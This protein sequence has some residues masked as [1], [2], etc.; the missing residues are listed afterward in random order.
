MQDKKKMYMIAIGAC[1]LA[2]GVFAAL[3]VIL[4]K[5]GDEEAKTEPE[6]QVEYAQIETS[7]VD[8]EWIDTDTYDAMEHEDSDVW[9][10]EWEEDEEEVPVDDNPLYYTNM[11]VVFDY[12]PIG[13]IKTLRDETWEFLQ[14]NSFRHGK[15]VTILEDQI[16]GD[17]DDVKFYFTVEELDGFLFSAH[18]DTRHKV[19][20]FMREQD[21]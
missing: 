6:T 2:V 5:R 14:H 19:V 4:N 12:L 17:R 9:K 21:P 18:Y 8:D 16:E 3:V 7:T 20:E 15:A 11:E 13:V 10:D 1:I